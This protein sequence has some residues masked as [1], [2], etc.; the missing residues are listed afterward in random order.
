MRFP[1][2]ARAQPPAGRREAC[3]RGLGRGRGQRL[4]GGRDQGEVTRVLRL[5]AVPRGPEAIAGALG[6][7]RPSDSE[8]ESPSLLTRAAATRHAG[9]PKSRQDGP[10]RARAAAEG[11]APD[12]ALRQPWRR[13]S[14]HLAESVPAARRSIIQQTSR[15]PAKS[16][17]IRVLRM[18]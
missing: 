2:P 3:G 12:P 17:W 1:G 6:A 13:G 10:S 18:V 8:S 16:R 11:G 7:G 14:R 4:P 9:A 5:P 15:R